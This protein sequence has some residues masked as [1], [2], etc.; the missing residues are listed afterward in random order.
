MKKFHT[1][2]ASILIGLGAQQIAAASPYSFVTHIIDPSRTIAEFPIQMVPPI[3]NLS[4]T[5][6]GF[7]A[8]ITWA[9]SAD[10]VVNL[11]MEGTTLATSP[12]GTIQETFVGNRT[13]TL[14]VTNDSGSCESSLTLRI[15]PDGVPIAHQPH[16]DG[17]LL[18]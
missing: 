2:V 17:D 10:S 16:I 4:A 3:C 11:S 14:L 7:E 15:S 12:S 13:V 8:T 9:T 1:F 18:K 5:L 6:D